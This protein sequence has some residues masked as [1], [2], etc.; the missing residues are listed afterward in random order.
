[1]QVTGGDTNVAA[2][3]MV[4]NAADGT[5]ATNATVTVTNFDLQYTRTLAAANAKS[6]GIVGTGGAATHVDNK[7]FEIDATSSPGLY[8]VCFV[9]GAFAAGAAEVH[10]ALT[11]PTDSVFAEVI[12][13]Q[14]DTPVILAN[15]TL[16]G[17]AATR[18]VLDRLTI[19]S[20]TA[21]T[22]AVS[23]TGNTTGQGVLCIGGATSEGV[24][25]R[26]G[27]TSG[28]ALRL[29]A[30]GGNDHGFECVGDGS[31]AGIHSTGGGTTGAGMEL[32]GGAGSG[33]CLTLTLGG[34][35]FTTN[36]IISSL[37]IA[38]NAIGA[39]ELATDAVEEIRDAILA[40]S[41]PFNG[42]N[43]DANN[44]LLKGLNVQHTTVNVYTS[45]T[46]FTLVAGATDN[47]AYNEYVC[48][49]TKST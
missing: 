23:I 42:A 18:V 29:F 3:F 28:S 12:K 5:A 22:P 27:A 48:V 34:G 26:G 30:D 37:N 38:A 31:G 35:D 17:G 9:D 1:M 24:E 32:V 21:A 36:D 40:D 20:G 7:V 16:H 13:C 44:L 25:L 49:I 45:Q 11:N 33:D 41:T 14:I 2:Y 10:L 43:V 19:A 39:S 15:N 8:L 46:Q 4:R 47:D 6:D